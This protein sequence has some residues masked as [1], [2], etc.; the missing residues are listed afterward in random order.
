MLTGEFEWRYL[1]VLCGARN[2]FVCEII[3]QFKNY[4]NVAYSGHIRAF[5]TIQNLLKS[6]VLEAPCNLSNTEA[7]IYT[8]W[9][10]CCLW[11]TRIGLGGQIC[12]HKTLKA[13]LNRK[14]RLLHAHLRHSRAVGFLSSQQFPCQ[15][16]STGWFWIIS[17]KLG[18]QSISSALLV[19]LWDTNFQLMLVMPSRDCQ[20]LGTV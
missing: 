19:L 2:T 3:S 13:E 20:G 12:P 4:K 1:G 14:T 7:T 10:P 17:R 6:H 8:S 15:G 18:L 5:M 11:R 9:P 16:S